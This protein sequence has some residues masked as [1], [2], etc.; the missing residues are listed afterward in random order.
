M[1][2][3]NSKIILGIDPGTRVTGYGLLKKN[4]SHIEALDFGCIRPPPKL[5]LGKRYQ[6]IFESIENLI[7]KYHP[8]ALSVET[9]YVQKNVSSAMKI[10]MARGMVILAAA[11]A[12]IP[13]FEYAP[14]KAKLAVAGNGSASKM[15]LQTMLQ[16]ILNL[17]KVAIPEDASDALAIAL[18]HAH[19]KPCL[20]I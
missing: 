8:H 19:E 15:Q 13:C 10:G 7:E 4:G 16:M 3:T 11:R 20:N 17:P 2:E 12:N 6:I 9:Q 1:S 14:K 18:C 5:E